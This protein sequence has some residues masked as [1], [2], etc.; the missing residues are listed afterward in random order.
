MSIFP[1]HTPTPDAP[2]RLV[3]QKHSKSSRPAF[4][5]SPA[6]SSLSERHEPTSSLRATHFFGVCEVRNLTRH[7]YLDTDKAMLPKR[8]RDLGKS[9]APQQA[10]GVKTHAKKFLLETPPE[11]GLTPTF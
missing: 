10:S 2:H 9:A 11:V 1:C 6:F 7:G 5:I 3:Q 4:N 8:N